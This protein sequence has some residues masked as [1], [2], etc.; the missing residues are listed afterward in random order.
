MLMHTYLIRTQRAI[1]EATWQQ[2]VMCLSLVLN[3]LLA[4]ASWTRD[5]VIHL[6]PA[7]AAKELVIA[8][9]TANQET[10]IAHALYLAGLLGNVSSHNAG[11]LESLA[12]RF[13]TPRAFRSYLGELQQQ[14]AKIRDEQLTTTFQA[15]EATYDPGTDFVSVT[16]LLVTRGVTDVERRDYRTFRFRFVTREHQT[17]LDELHVRDEHTRL[18]AGG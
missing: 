12:S 14:A 1:R 2:I 5:I 13:V 17:L 7:A 9:R 16:G 15:M 6:P 11:F 4:A 8:E 3:L 10:K 18:A